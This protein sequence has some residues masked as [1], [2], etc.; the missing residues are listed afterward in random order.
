MFFFF[1]S[2]RYGTDSSLKLNGAFSVCVT[3]GVDMLGGLGVTGP[4]EAR[5]VRLLTEQSG[6]LSWS[7]VG[8][9]GM[10]GSGRKR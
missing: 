2:A 10:L 5:A 9:R 8:R 1:S 7:A 4:A 6:G 3:D